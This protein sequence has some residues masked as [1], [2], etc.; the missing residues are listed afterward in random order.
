MSL[1]LASVLMSALLGLGA[2]LLGCEKKEKSRAEKVED[3]AKDA[4][5]LREHEK[6]KD[7]GEDAKDALED[8]R[9]AA[10]EEVGR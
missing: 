6:L 8:A 9:D 1:P 3:G 5:G 2:P 10:K 7:A 4:L